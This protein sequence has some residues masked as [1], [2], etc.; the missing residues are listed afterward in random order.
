MSK[1]IHFEFGAD[2]PKRAIKFYENVFRWKIT[3][4][5]GN[6][7]YWMVKAG[8]DSEMGTNGAIAPRQKGWAISNSIGV[9]SVDEYIER[10]EMNGGEVT[11]EKMAV[12]NMGYMAYFKDTEGNV[13][14]IFESD[15]KAK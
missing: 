7:D 15:P 10:I 8:D 11:T 6:V 2:E 5:P 4:Y 1:V 12:P 3:K 9:P 13:L 14:S